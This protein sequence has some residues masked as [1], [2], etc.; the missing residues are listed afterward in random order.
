LVR[1][2]AVYDGGLR[3]TAT[4]MPSGTT[5]V[6]DAPVD[7]QGKGESFSP[8]DLLAT[9]ALNCMMTI[10]AIGADSRGLDVSGMSGSVE[11]IMA[12][13]PRRVARLEIEIALPS[14]LSTEE[15]EFLI[16]RG[17]A[18]PVHKSV[19]DEMELDVTFS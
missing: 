7:N 3:C 2:E 15:R 9:S 14:Y 5:L 16:R 12:S 6:T 19:S 10:I 18:C 4:H 17:M 11:K 1:I 8:T 13:G